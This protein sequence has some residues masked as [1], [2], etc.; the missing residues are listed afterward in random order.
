MA[1]GLVD[2]KPHSVQKLRVIFDKLHR[3][4]DLFISL[5]DM[6]AKKNLEKINLNEKKT[7]FLRGELN[8]GQLKFLKSNR[9]LN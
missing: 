5:Y 2:T 4:L 8:L 7:R 3:I 1:N 6:H 9:N